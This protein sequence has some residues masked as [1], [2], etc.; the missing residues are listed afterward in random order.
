MSLTTLATLNRIE[1]QL[2]QDPNRSIFCI[3]QQ[4]DI[5]GAPEVPSPPAL[6]PSLLAAA[7]AEAAS[8]CGISMSMTSPCGMAP[9]GMGTETTS[10]GA[11]SGWCIGVACGAARKKSAVGS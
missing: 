7:A 8:T 5:P 9:S 3:V 6:P 11:Y 2:L 4:Y 1:I 10:T